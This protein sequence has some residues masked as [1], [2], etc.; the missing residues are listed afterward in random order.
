VPCSRTD[1]P[2]AQSGELVPAE[3]DQIL[4]GMQMATVRD[5]ATWFDIGDA[6]PGA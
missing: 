4:A 2:R 5:P 1:R 6:I 3:L